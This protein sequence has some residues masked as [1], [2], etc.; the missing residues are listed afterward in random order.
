MWF[1]VLLFHCLPDPGVVRRSARATNAGRYLWGVSGF[2]FAH[3]YYANW[4]DRFR[5]KAAAW[6]REKLEA[7]DPVEKMRAL[8]RTLVARREEAEA[9]GIGPLDPAYPG[10][11]DELAKLHNTGGVDE[12]AKLYGPGK[13]GD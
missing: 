7:L 1:L 5:K 8:S 12:L 9:R 6:H 3:A 13:A 11:V 10:W 4:Y 2:G